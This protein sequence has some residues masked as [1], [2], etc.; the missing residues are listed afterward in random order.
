MTIEKREKL[1]QKQQS[2]KELSASVLRDL[3]VYDLKQIIDAMAQKFPAALQK[4]IDKAKKL[5]ESN[6][7][8]D[9]YIISHIKVEWFN[10]KVWKQQF[11]SSLDCPRPYLNFTVFKYHRK[12]DMVEELWCLP[13]RETLNFYYKNRHLASPDEYK[14]VDYCIKYKDGTLYK[15]MQS[16]NG[17]SED[18]PMLIAHDL[19]QFK[20]PV[21]KGEKE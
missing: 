7:T 15:M 5:Y 4:A 16:L 2:L 3:E 12:L 6:P 19:S 17:E 10:P 11:V 14:M 1:N 18:K 20:E 13:D 21:I 9:F 8:R